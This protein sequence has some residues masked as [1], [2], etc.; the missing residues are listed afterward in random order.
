V[1]GTP[2]L[3]EEHASV[4]QR[5]LWLIERHEG[6][7]GRL[8]YPLLLRLRGPLDLAE[9]QRAVDTLVSRHETLRTT[10]G[11]RQGMLTQLIHE[12][13]PVAITVVPSA[14]ESGP[15]LRKAIAD[16]VA[17]PI[18]A[19]VAPVRLTLWPTAPAE[20]VLCLN[21]HHMVTDA[22]SCRILVEELLLL[23]GHAPA[24]PRQGWQ[25][26]HFVQWQRRKSTAELLRA[27]RA[28]WQRQLGGATA[29]ALPMRSPGAAGTRS[30]SCSI[31]A[32]ADRGSWERLRDIAR[33]EQA[34]PFTLLLSIYYLLLYRESGS[35]DLSVSSPF[36][37]RA[38]P[39]VM[40]TVGFFA[41]MLVLRTQLQPGSTFIDLLRRTR[42][43]VS[44]A[45]AHQAFPHFLP[46]NAPSAD[47]G[48]HV[49]DVVMQLL[50]E[51]PPPATAAG[52]GIEVIPPMVASRFDLELSVVAHRGGLRLL[53]QYSPDR[54]DNLLVERLAD[55][56]ATLLRQVAAAP[57][58]GI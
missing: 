15:A 17:A 23:L 8:N 39:E 47:N 28:Y 55:G 54:V 14:A 57:D 34:T 37:N 4:G 49:K 50:P 22:W 7:S 42:A 13:G 18:D 27:D 45:L 12:P 33:A 40:R 53:F 3:R 24:L 30:S 51:L 56:A 35:L 6:S 2:V 20:H 43:T 26:R 44:E 5:M 16:E 10:F 52:L 32:N 38:R 29:P 19:K 1:T 58:F 46:E 25:Y 11:R 21:A 31:E 36:A 9:L 41:N 48:V